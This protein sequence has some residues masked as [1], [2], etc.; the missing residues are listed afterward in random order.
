MRQINL[1]ILAHVDAGK[2]TL[3]ECCLYHGGVIRKL[4]RV[5]NRNSYFDSNPL[6]KNKGITIFTKTAGF[7]WQGSNITL[8]DTPG[9]KD[10]AG[11]MERTLQILDEIVLVISGLDGVQ[12]QS[13]MIFKLSAQY[14]LPL[15]VFINKMDLTNFT[16]Q[17]LL[18][19]LNNKLQGNFVPFN[20][21]ET[22]SVA[23]SDER[24]LEEYLSTG[25]L[26]VESIVQA[27][28]DRRIFP[29]YFGSALKDQG[30]VELLNG[31]VKFSPEKKYPQQ[32]GLRIF[33]V[34]YDNNTRWCYGK[35]TGG[36]LT[37]KQKLT[38]DEKVDQ[39]FIPSSDKFIP[40]NKVEAGQIVAIKGLK[41][42]TA[43]SGVGSEKNENFSHIKAY[44]QYSVKAS[45]N[46]DQKE[47]LKQ[48]EMLR[49]EDPSIDIIYQPQLKQYCLSLMGEI[50][51]EVIES[52][53]KQRSGID[54]SLVSPQVVYKET[55]TE[56]IIG[57]GHFEPLRHYAE[58]HVLLE[59]LERNS[60]IEIV[61]GL[62]NDELSQG[63]QTAIMNSLQSK[64]FKGVLTG[65]EIT[66]MRIT[67]IRAK[68]SLKH[69]ES[70]DF[71]QA[72]YRAIRNGLKRGKNILLEPYYEFVIEVKRE[73]VSKVLFDLEKMNAQIQL[74]QQSDNTIITGKAAVR[75][76]NEYITSF[77]S[78][79]SGT[80]KIDYKL[81]GYEQCCNSEEIIEKINYDS[82][83]DLDHPTGSIFCSHGSGFYVPY[84]Y[85]S[86]YMHVKEDNDRISSEIAEKNHAVS[87]S[88]LKKVFADINGR[89]RKNKKMTEK[90]VYKET[91]TPKKVIIK[92]KLL[93]V[94]GYNIIYSYEKTKELMRDSL[95]SARDILINDVASYSGYLGCKAIIVFDAYKREENTGKSFVNG[96]VTVVYTKQGQSADSYIEKL[97]HDHITDYRITVATSDRAVQDMV[98]GC[99]AIRMSAR[100]L[101]LNLEYMH[102]QTDSK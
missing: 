75:L 59:P 42:L 97:V 65:S 100:E 74:S 92:P 7:S 91:Y 11:E 24:L 83:A 54:V 62:D 43:G 61:N 53:I 93:I 37:A 35:V 82:E 55:L 3:N 23:L 25:T 57:Y 21:F 17:Q 40:V 30:I 39:L 48:L 66:D 71:R 44:M 49:Q 26:A 95:D 90:K 18:A 52:L 5:D 12:S 9:H 77:S 79:C 38:E 69:T 86:D 33:K 88:E 101:Q 60:G 13:E 16:Q 6:E 68:G 50:Q 98:L 51:I 94:D 96:S 36:T 84:D 34:A 32:F 45:E 85:V 20:D 99:G 64:K 70:S 81:S 2:T 27:I 14:N 56:S 87:D 8:V 89:N 46:V 29:V 10:F 102:K 41:I 1:G 15:F 22:E 19:D 73:Y 76:M 80:G 4:G 58:V 78:Q 67:V 72:V 31:I 47:L 63:W 28:K